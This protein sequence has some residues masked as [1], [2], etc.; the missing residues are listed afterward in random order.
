MNNIV[1]FGSIIIMIIQDVGCLKCYSTVK[2]PIETV[3]CAGYC[4]VTIIFL[5]YLLN[6]I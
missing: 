4:G 1:L 3:D 2:G 5:F 6:W